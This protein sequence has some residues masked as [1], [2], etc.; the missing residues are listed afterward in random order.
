MSN[1]PSRLTPLSLTFLIVTKS[2]TVRLCGLSAVNVITF[3]FG[4]ASKVQLLMNLGFLSNKKSDFVSS[5][6]LLNSDTDVIPVLFDSWI[7]NPFSGFLELS[8]SFGIDILSLYIFSSKLLV[9]DTL[10]TKLGSV[11]T[12]SKLLMLLKISFPVLTFIYHCVPSHRTGW[13]TSPLFLSV[14]LLKTLNLWVELVLYAF[15]N[16]PLSAF[17]FDDATLKVVLLSLIAK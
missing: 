8:I 15:I 13:P 16:S 14:T 1:A 6:V 4:E 5:S 17:V 10:F 11:L 9:S 12:S 2:P 7:I 3:G